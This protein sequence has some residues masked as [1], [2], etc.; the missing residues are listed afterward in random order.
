[1]LN[2]QLRRPLQQLLIDLLMKTTCI[3]PKSVM[4]G[5]SAILIG[6][7]AIATRIFIS[8]VFQFMRDDILLKL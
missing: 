1:V 2:L 4:S 5:T 3:A 7:H 6:L 8:L